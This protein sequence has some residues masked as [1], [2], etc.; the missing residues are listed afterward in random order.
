MPVEQDRRRGTSVT[1]STVWPASAELLR[2]CS[3]AGPFSAVPGSAEQA[4]GSWLAQPPPW[5]A[6][7]HETACGDKVPHLHLPPLLGRAQ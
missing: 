3:R 2:P 4:A 7:G 5:E 1:W 6:P